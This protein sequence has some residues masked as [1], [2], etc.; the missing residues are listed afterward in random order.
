MI[1]TFVH[2]GG[3]DFSPSVTSCHLP[4]QMEASFRRV[5]DATPY[6]RN[7]PQVNITSVG[8]ITHE[9]NITHKVHITASNGLHHSPVRHKQP[10]IAVVCVNVSPCETHNVRKHSKLITHNSP[11]QIGDGGIILQA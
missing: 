1:C 8:H 9:V 6:N 11:L 4:R 3:V 7:S 5:E 10:W 2:C